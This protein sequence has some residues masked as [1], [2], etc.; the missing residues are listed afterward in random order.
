MST[1]NGQPTY[2]YGWD[3][4]FA[5]PIPYV[6][7]AIVDHGSSP[8][9]FSY[10]DSDLSASADFG[11]WQV[12]Q[13]GDG[14]AVYLSLPMTNIALV[15]KATN[16]TLGFDSGSAIIEVQLEYLP[17]T[18]AS[19][20]ST[21]GTPNQLIVKSQGTDASPP[22]V[23]VS[24]DIPGADGITLA[25]FGAGLTNWGN[26]NL[27]QFAHV[28]AVVDLNNDVDQGEWGFVTPKDVGYAYLDG[29][30]LDTSVLAVL[31]T[32]GSRTSA[33][34]DL[35]VSPSA[36]PGTSI[37]GFLISQARVM[38]DLI[39]SA[40]CQAYPG[41]QPQDLTLSPDGTTLTL[42]QG[43][44][45]NLAPVTH[46][47][48]QYNP[49]LT[50]LTAEATG[51]TITLTSVT[52]TYIR[53]GITAVCVS[54]HWYG[55]VLATSSNGQTLQFVA[56]QSPSIVH[57]IH[58]SDGAKITELIIMIV[59]AIALL[60]LA[61]LTDG[62]AL[63]AGGLVI[64]LLMG[65][66]QIVPALIEKANTDDSPSIDLL[67]ANST[68]PITWTDSSGFS[69]DYAGLNVSLQLGGDPKFV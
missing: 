58:Q 68:S 53:L 47:G 44:T 64:G 18:D 17:T 31:C 65:A 38:D 62:A 34:L 14:K 67:L 1:G 23:F 15:L 33:D 49:Q 12:V 52:E 37:A 35:Q 25:V 16:K 43:V 51:S 20:S 54:T 40:I 59:G 3:T 60:I 69:L 30:T 50:G 48:T 28:F 8:K 56:T 61:V 5:I 29:P 22:V 39:R 36:I 9:N 19:P 2:T 6:N 46:D 55:L 4:V 45:A 41:I 7:K 13:G 57:S 27:A 21:G 42:Q 32:T 24:G 63:I 66:S 11:N 26:A 10:S